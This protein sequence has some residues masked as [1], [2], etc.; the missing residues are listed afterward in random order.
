MTSSEI[1]QSI[2]CNTCRLAGFA[3]CVAVIL[4]AVYA[5]SEARITEQRLNA[6]RQ[7][8]AVIFPANLHDNDLINDRISLDLASDKFD[9]LELLGLRESSA[10]FIARSNNEP[11]GIILPLVARDGYNGDIHLLLGI[12]ADSSVTAVRVISHR[13]TP[14][15][16]DLIDL[17]F[18]DWILSFNQRS[19]QNP[20]PPGWTVVK[21]GGEFDQ[22]TGATITPR[23]VT[24]AVARALEFFEINKAVIMNL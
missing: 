18:S 8:L 14:G 4:T 10:A 3:A 7:A 1:Q 12:R 24:M 6:E 22:F 19:L 9:N 11:I 2:I 20:A 15:L 16:G 23:S 13:E 21:N 17:R 5:I